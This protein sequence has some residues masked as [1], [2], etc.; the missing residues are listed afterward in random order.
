MFLWFSVALAAP[1]EAVV[2]V[3]RFRDDVDAVWERIGTE[4]VK[5]ARADALATEAAIA[6]LDGPVP[7]AVAA[8]FHRNRA[9]VSLVSQDPVGALAAAAAARRLAP[10]EAV[11]WDERSEDF[12]GL[13]TAE[14][15]M[16]SVE[17]FETS[18]AA[19]VYADGR[20]GAQRHSGQPVIV[21]VFAPDGTP[22]DGAW[23][24]AREVTPSWVTYPP[25][26]CEGDVPVDRVVQAAQGAQRA[27]EA[28]DVPAFVGGLE[29]VAADLPCV[30]DVVRP[31]AAAVIHRLEGIRL[32]T[33]G[34]ATAAVRAFQEA[35]TLDPAYT[36]AEESMP[37][38]GS[39]A[40]YW[41]R[42]SALSPPPWLPEAPP[43]GL[44]MWVDGLQTDR[45]PATLP[46][47]VQLVDPRGEVVWTRFVPATVALPP[48]DTLEV[49]VVDPLAG[50]APAMAVYK[51]AERRERVLARRRGLRYLGFGALVGTAGMLVANAAY[52]VSFYDPRTHPDRLQGRQRATNA[53]FVAGVAFGTVAVGALGASEW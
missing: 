45:R 33:Q 7:T 35:Q 28:L 11:A 5:Y 4:G 20:P 14:L 30:D 31:E 23:I 50:F 44:T 40:R 21:Q 19:R 36:P 34:S 16:P 47:I 26:T 2:P 17:T 25:L 51:A 41:D 32:F 15:P 3:E 37:P 46:T 43:P 29:T 22:L 1:C 49:E 10:E 24:P 39:L 42:A 48:L 9:L 18:L 53:T 8:A 38:G 27:F 52:S 12:R 6:C 13:V